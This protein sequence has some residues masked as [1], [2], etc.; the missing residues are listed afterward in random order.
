MKS[1]K[2]LG[3]DGWTDGPDMPVY[4]AYFGIAADTKIYVLGGRNYELDGTLGATNSV[5]VYDPE[6]NSWQTL[7]PLNEP[8]QFLQAAISNGYL[9]AIGG[10]N[11]SETDQQG[12]VEA[13]PLAQTPETASN[14]Y[15]MRHFGQ[16]QTTWAG[17]SNT[18]TAADNWPPSR[19]RPAM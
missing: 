4:K 16:K 14:A 8:R 9:Y 10:Y 18:P 11:R 15:E 1:M 19:T 2:I 5:H 12:T 17:R 6:F 7:D 13:L 3:P